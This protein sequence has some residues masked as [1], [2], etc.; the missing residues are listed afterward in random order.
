MDVLSNINNNPVVAQHGSK[1]AL[2]ISILLLL[3]FIIT[4]GFTIRADAKVK[5]E[6]YAPQPVQA[7][8]NRNNRPRYRI[9]DVVSANLFG[10]PAPKK[11]VNHA[12]K[13][14]LNLELQGILAATDNNVARAIILSGKN[15]KSTKGGLYSVGE[16]IEGASGTSVK[17]I[18]SNEV[19]LNRNG[20]VESLPLIKPT[21]K[22]DT[23]VYTPLDQT[24][25][26]NTASSKNAS[27][28]ASSSQQRNVKKPNFSGLD[29][30]QNELN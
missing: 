17:E 28:T 8:S 13:T 26:A 21:S 2:V 11:V 27:Q 4:C 24:S 14:T 22:G 25:R 3:I 9:N 19:I 18:R 20:S 15:N 10:N 6:N 5:A 1:I 29:Q 12:P 7:V 16:Q 30:T 23:S